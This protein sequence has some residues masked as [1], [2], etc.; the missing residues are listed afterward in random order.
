[1]ALIPRR[2]ALEIEDE[3]GRRFI[4][5]L[6]NKTSNQVSETPIDTCGGLQI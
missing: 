4:F 6:I 5:D 1:M 3:T 2:D